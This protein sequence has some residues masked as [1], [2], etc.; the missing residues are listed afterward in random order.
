MGS[1]NFEFVFIYQLRIQTFWHIFSFDAYSV[2]KGRIC[3]FKHCA[4][5]SQRS[6]CK[7]STCYIVTVNYSLP[8]SSHSKSEGGMQENPNVSALN[9][10]GLPYVGAYQKPENRAKN[11]RKPQNREKFVQNRKPNKTPHSQS[12]DS[13]QN[14]RL[15]LLLIFIRINLFYFPEFILD[16]PWFAQ[17]TSQPKKLLFYV[18]RLNEPITM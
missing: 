18:N 6:F 11:R 2:I 13:L 4:C 12:L 16:I 7:N 10:K 9:T 1:Q 8:N 17:N 14:L 5:L 3:N 15:F